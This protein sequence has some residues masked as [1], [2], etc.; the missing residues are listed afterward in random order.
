MG[1]P[2]FQVI[3]CPLLSLPEWNNMS[4]GKGTAV[5]KSGCGEDWQKGGLQ[6]LQL[7]AYLCQEQGTYITSS[8]LPGLL[9]LTVWLNV[10]QLTRWIH[11][12]T[13]HILVSVIPPRISL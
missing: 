12:P 9:V 8:N 13:L 7:Y 6:G 4:S 1:K 3:L 11:T 10:P 5:R 2:I